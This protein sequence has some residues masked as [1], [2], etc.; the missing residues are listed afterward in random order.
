MPLS[1]IDHLCLMRYVFFDVLR[2]ARRKDKEASAPGEDPKLYLE[3]AVLERKHGDLDLRTLVELPAGLDYNEW[4]ASHSEYLVQT[5]PNQSTPLI[6][7][8]T[9]LLLFSHF[10][11]FPLGHADRRWSLSWAKAYTHSHWVSGWVGRA[12]SY[13]RCKLATQSAFQLIT[14]YPRSFKLMSCPVFVHLPYLSAHY[15]KVGVNKWN[16]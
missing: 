4:L 9:P 2:K 5:K 8:F 11:Q 10:N 6:C 1:S 16:N 14:I 13:R 12:S 7:S 3:E 15:W